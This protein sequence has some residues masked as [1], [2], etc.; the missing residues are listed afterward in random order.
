MA[1]YFHPRRF[2]NDPGVRLISQTEDSDFPALNLAELLLNQGGDTFILMLIFFIRS[3]GQSRLAA[4]LTGEVGKSLVIPGETGA[5]VRQPP[6]E[7]FTA[8]PRVISQQA[9]DRLGITAG[10]LFTEL[11]QRIGKAYLHGNVGIERYFSQLRA[12]D[13]G[14]DDG[15]I[16]ITNLP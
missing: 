7:I 3:H 11:R 2:L 10:Y 14:P 15:G 4:N 5:A 13:V 1:G 8:Y 16:I 6:G 12:V 9:A